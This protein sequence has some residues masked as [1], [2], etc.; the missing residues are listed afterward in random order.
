MY[1]GYHLSGGQN[2]ILLI[3]LPIWSNHAN[4]IYIN[5]IQTFYFPL[6]YIMSD[7]CLC[8]IIKPVN[9]D[10]LH[11]SAIV[12]VL[13]FQCRDKTSMGSHMGYNT[14]PLYKWKYASIWLIPF[15]IQCSELFSDLAAHWILYQCLKFHSGKLV[16]FTSPQN[17][18][19]NN[20]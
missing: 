6:L 15:G 19:L 4:C 14:I 1:Q 17:R 20:C 12:A 16:N 7:S 3:E 2:V 8:L 10:Q 18:M 11:V 13:Y 9:E 5:K